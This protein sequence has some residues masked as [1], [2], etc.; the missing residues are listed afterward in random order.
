[1]IPDELTNKLIELWKICFQA[2]P[3]FAIGIL[4]FVIWQFLLKPIFL[5]GVQPGVARTP[6]DDATS[7][8]T[9]LVENGEKPE[10]EK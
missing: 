3:V 4:V 2:N 5:G 1:M 9:E 7:N 8:K 10:S 6:A